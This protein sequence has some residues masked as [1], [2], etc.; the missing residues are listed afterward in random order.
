MIYDVIIIGGGAAGLFCAA[1]APVG[2]GLILDQSKTTGLKLL[3]SGSGQCNLTNAKNIKDFILEY[4]KNG[5]RIRTILYK[6]NNQKTMEFFESQ[7]LPLFVR[8]DLKVFPKSLNSKDVKDILT[9]NANKNNF[10]IKTGVKVTKI[11][12]AD[13]GYIVNDEYK[14]QNLVIATGGASYPVTGSDGSIFEILKSLDL[15]IVDIKPA[16]APIYVQ[17]YQFGD[18]SGLSFKDCKFAIHLDSKVAV[19]DFGDVLLTHTGFS[20]PGILKVSRYANAGAKLVIDFAPDLTAKFDGNGITKSIGNY[21][22]EGTQLPK[23]F[24]T[25]LLSLYNIDFGTKTSTLSQKILNA[26]FDEIHSMTL[27]ISGTSGFKEAMVTCGG[28]SLDEISTKTMESKKHPGLYIIG[29]VLDVDGNTGGYNL[30]F[31]FSSGYIA[32]QQIS[33]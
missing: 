13:F 23:R 6:F 27:S 8:E 17:N 12:K 5:K 11:D 30:Q 31:A 20:G 21:I 7:G 3:M 2:S 25:K 9:K 10:E 33:L 16:L 4:G 1:N 28:V 18:L 14:C 22:C 15:D 26:L 19:H 29:E 24:V 32:A